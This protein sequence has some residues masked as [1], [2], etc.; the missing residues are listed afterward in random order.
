MT[1]NDELNQ[2]SN[3]N[4]EFSKYEEPDVRK[5]SMTYQTNFLHKFKSLD[6][7]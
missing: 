6:G 2:K 4:L 3:D 7:N 1:L 5:M